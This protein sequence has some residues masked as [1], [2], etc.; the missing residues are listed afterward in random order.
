MALNSDFQSVFKNQFETAASLA[1]NFVANAGKI[2]N[3]VQDATVASMQAQGRA[4]PRRPP[5]LIRSGRAG[6]HAA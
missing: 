5:D 2:A 4:F 3:E 6:V 1:G